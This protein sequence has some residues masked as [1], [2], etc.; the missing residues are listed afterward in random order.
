MSFGSVQ[1]LKSAAQP[2]VN[3]GV[4]MNQAGARQAGHYSAMCSTGNPDLQNDIFGRPVGTFGVDMRGAPECAVYLP[5]GQSPMDHI[6]RE[7]LE[8]PYVAIAPSGAR[9]SGDMMGKGRQVMPQDLY[10]TGL[11]G[12]FIRWGSPGL[13]IPDRFQSFPFNDAPPMEGRFQST[14]YPTTHDTTSQY[15]YRG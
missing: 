5:S 9:G 6:T 13:T 7:N 1:T 10:G 3:I 4:S 14:V 12:N 2:R 8:R 11:A 15:V